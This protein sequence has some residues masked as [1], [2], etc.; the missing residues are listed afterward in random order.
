MRIEVRV[1]PNSKKEG[2]ARIDEGVY[3]VRVS[4][5]PEKGRAN[6]RVLDLLSKHLRVRKSSLRIVK[7]ERARVKVIEIE[8]TP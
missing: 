6:E 8:G 2:V 4:V 5:P 1:K 3:E 7:G